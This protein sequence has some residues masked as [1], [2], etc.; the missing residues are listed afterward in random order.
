MPDCASARAVVQRAVA[1]ARIPD[2]ELDAALTHIEGCARCSPR[3]D[4]ARTR[5]FLQRS[6]LVTELAEPAEP[7]A[8]FERVLTAALSSS[9]TIVRIRAAERLGDYQRLGPVALD[10]LAEAAADD[11]DEEVRETAL[12]ALDRLDAEVSLPQRLIEQW[13]ETPAAA[14]PY[15]ADVLARLSTPTGHPPASVTQLVASFSEAAEQLVVSGE[16]GITGQVSRE[17]DELW[18]R[19]HQL[20]HRLENAK[21]VVAVPSALE[22]DAP[23]VGWTGASPGLVPA[24]APVAGGSLDVMLGSVLEPATAAV[25]ETLFGRVYLLN[26][27]EQTGL[28]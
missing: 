13:S 9:E 17:K 8:R 23:P 25:S 3:F 6:D 22:Q 2:A 1:G 11:E 4:L 27:R 18:L 12:E 20:P 24:P 7:I 5:S 19:L 16:E 21:P 10:A 14:A 28:V 26:P 15:L